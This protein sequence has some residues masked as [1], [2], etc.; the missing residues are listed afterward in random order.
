MITK[1]TPQAEIDK[2]C[3]E[4][5]AEMH[6]LLAKYNASFSCTIEGDTHGIDYTEAYLYL[7][8][9]GTW[10]EIKVVSAPYGSDIGADDCKP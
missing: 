5:K 6:N 9:K 8:V 1:D 3:Q 10:Q 2:I 7:G 4:F